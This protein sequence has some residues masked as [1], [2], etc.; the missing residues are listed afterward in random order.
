MNE[1]TASQK[2]L[3][4]GE[5]TI[6]FYSQAL[7]NSKTIIWNGPM[8]LYE[9]SPFSAGTKAVA[10]AVADSGAV[11]VLGGGDT[12]D[13]VHHFGFTSKEFSHISTGGG[14]MLEFLEGKSLPGVQVLLK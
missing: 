12:I 6:E 11:S 8:G 2:I 7:K 3:D 4:L 1:V 14:A 9:M 10:K 5:K 13:A